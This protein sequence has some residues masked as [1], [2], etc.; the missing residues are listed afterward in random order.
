M[1][2]DHR[3]LRVFHNAHQLVLAIYRQTK[4]FP[5][6][7]WFGIR[8][9]MRRAAASVPTNIVEGSARRTTSEYVNF[10]NVARGSAGELHYLIDLASQLGFLAGDAF[11]DLNAKTE[12]VVRQLERLIQELEKLLALEREVRRNRSK[13]IESPE[14]R[15]KRLEQGISSAEPGKAEIP[16]RPALGSRL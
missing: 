1:A 16:E 4:A 11:K 14:Q 12:H 5:K 15:S 10:V 7:E 2:R 9:Q 13:K 8:L 3:K 6:D